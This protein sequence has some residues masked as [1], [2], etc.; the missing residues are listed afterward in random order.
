MSSRN[1]SYETVTAIL[2]S[3]SS[4]PKFGV[5]SIYKKTLELFGNRAA[6]E[7]YLLSK[8]GFD[9]AE[10]DAVKRRIVQQNNRIR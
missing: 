5:I 7:K 1:V 6:A 3:L 4:Q 9:Q 8:G 2:Y 10:L